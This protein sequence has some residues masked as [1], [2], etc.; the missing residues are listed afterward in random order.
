MRFVIKLIDYHWSCGDGCC[1]DSGWK[2][3]VQDNEPERPG[4]GCVV[5]DTDWSYNHDQKALLERGV[6]AIEKKLGRKSIEGQDY[7]V[8]EDYESSDDD[9]GD[10]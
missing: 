7:Y 5:E 6:E 8:Q 3:Y 9:K 4:Y 1:S 10:W 2:L